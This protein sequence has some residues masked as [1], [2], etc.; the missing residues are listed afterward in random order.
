MYNS[1]SNIFHIV[2]IIYVLIILIKT[3]CIYLIFQ[4]NMNLYAYMNVYI[5]MVNDIIAT[6]IEIITP[7]P[8]S[9]YIYFN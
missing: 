3:P 8:F 2:Y 1:L 5:Y 7:N 6:E 4:Q 9:F